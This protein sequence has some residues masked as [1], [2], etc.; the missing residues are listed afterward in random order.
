METPF[1]TPS[2][3]GRRLDCLINEL[4]STPIQFRQQAISAAVEGTIREIVELTH[5]DRGSLMELSGPRDTIDA[6]YEYPP[7]SISDE[8]SGQDPRRWSWIVQRLANADEPVVYGS[9]REGAR[10]E[11]PQGVASAIGIPVSIGE[12][13]MCMLALETF[14]TPRAWPNAI[15]ERLRNLAGVLAAELDRLRREATL[16]ATRAG[17]VARTPR[18]GEGSTPGTRSSGGGFGIA[19]ESAPLRAALTRLQQVAATD[20]TVPAAR[21]NRHRQGIVRSGA[22]RIQRSRQIPTGHDQL[23]RPAALAGRKRTVR[24]RAWRIHRRHRATTRTVRGGASRNAVPRRNRRPAARYPGEIAARAAGPH[25]RAAWILADA[26]R[27]RADRRRNP[28]PP[29]GRGGRRR[30]P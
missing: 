4:S 21:G 18:P 12:H 26:D 3:E 19:G 11:L 20:A 28:S 15:V 7:P 9:T 13:H 1:S 5:V 25:I 24:I 16:F 23:R 27:R 29:R 2:D 6:L 17:P 30:V 8:D 14:A 22:S 10:G